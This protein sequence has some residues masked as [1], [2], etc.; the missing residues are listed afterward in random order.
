MT[1]KDALRKYIKNKE[2]LEFIE[3]VFEGG[4]IIRLGHGAMDR[5][6]SSS[7]SLGD[8]LRIIY[9]EYNT[10][11]RITRLLFYLGYVIKYIE[12][13]NDHYIYEWKHIDR[14]LN[15]VR[16]DGL[17]KFLLASVRSFSLGFHSEL[18]IYDHMKTYNFNSAIW[19]AP[20]MSEYSEEYDEV[21]DFIKK[22]KRMPNDF[23][24]L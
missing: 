2:C 5:E 4:E 17:K 10:S 23:D 20:S 18:S 9:R 11:F 15:E 12:T 7:D 22:Y 16:D 1:A 3:D 19:I 14:W 24:D 21:I 8:I 6:V 13:S